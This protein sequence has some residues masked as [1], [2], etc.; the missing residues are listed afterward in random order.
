MTLSG[1]PSTAAVARHP[2]HPMVVPLPIASAVL[3]FVSD[4]LATRSG[5]DW[6]A[7]TAH[8]LLGTCV[9]TGLMAA[10]SG[11]IDALT[12]RAA[13]SSPM[14]WVHAGGNVAALGIAGLEWLRRGRGPLVASRVSLPVTG[15]VAGILFVTGWLGGELA[16]RKGIGVHLEEPG[17]DARPSSPADE[18]RLSALTGTADEADT[19]TS[20]HDTLGMPDGDLPAEGRRDIG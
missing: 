12:V 19:D 8:W 16:Y 1:H 18:A 5:Q 7:R 9:A 6:H 11:A 2:I 3:A 17:P 20:A 15:L 13:R 4:V 10:P 14:T